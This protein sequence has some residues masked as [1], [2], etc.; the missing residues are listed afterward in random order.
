MIIVIIA[1]TLAVLLFSGCISLGGIF[2]DQG[3]DCGADSKNATLCL[4]DG[5]VNCIAGTKAQLNTKT[6]SM[7]YEILGKINGTCKIKRTIYANKVAE[8]YC[9]IEQA[10]IT[11]LI[12]VNVKNC[13]VTI[14]K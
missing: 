3:K 14:L 11:N 2:G 4:S 6:G 12:E 13:N 5:I 1:M 10:P 9:D 7:N 8:Y